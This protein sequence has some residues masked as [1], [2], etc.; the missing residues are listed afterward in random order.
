MVEPATAVHAA[1]AH[2]SAADRQDARARQRRPGS[3]H[4][5]QGQ[6]P[7]QRLQALADA[8]PQVAQLQR[9]QA[10]ADGAVL[11]TRQRKTPE[12]E[13]P[14][15]G[16][17]RTVQRQS[18]EDE[19]LLQG[20]FATTPAT[21]AP[22]RTGMTDGL[23]SG[24]EALSG[25]TMDHVRVHYNSEKPAQLNAHAYA[26]GSDIHLAPG[27]DRHLP[28]E[29]WHLVQQAQG[30]VQPTLQLNGGVAVNDDPSLEHEADQ[31]GE[32]ALVSAS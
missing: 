18:P 26:Q 14:L 1:S 4:A 8:S 9:L 3:D 6:S 25:L 23:K 7:L 32:R 17:F 24:I 21:P 13:E 2:A 5:A 11:G 31:M 12:E 27:Q 19:E 15:Q 16:R 28:H 20:K 30:R 10:L 29:A 22:N